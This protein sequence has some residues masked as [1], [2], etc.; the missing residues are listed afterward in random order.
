MVPP[1]DAADVHGQDK[2]RDEVVELGRALLMAASTP[3]PTSGTSADEEEVMVR[4]LLR[5]WRIQA[6]SH[7]AHTGC[8]PAK[9]AL[10]KRQ[11]DILGS[12]LVLSVDLTMAVKVA[13]V[14][15]AV[16]SLRCPH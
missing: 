12:T 2:S 9:Y 11:E 1:K 10:V 6:C 15:S 7:Y 14:T 3:K 16:A 13:H 5:S 4:N 8:L